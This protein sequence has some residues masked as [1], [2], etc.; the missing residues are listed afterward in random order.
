MEREALFGPALP[1]LDTERPV[2]IGD[3]SGNSDDQ[4]DAIE[5]LAGSAAAEPPE[6]RRENPVE[7]ALAEPQESALPQEESAEPYHEPAREETA[8]PAVELPPQAQAPRI[9]APPRQLPNAEARQARWRRKAP[10]AATQKEPQPRRSPFRS[11][12]Q[13]LHQAFANYRSAPQ[14]ARPQK[15][16]SGS[17]SGTEDKKLLWGER[18]QKNAAQLEIDLYIRR[19]M[20]ALK[21]R[22]AFYEET[23]S[24]S[25][26]VH[27]RVSVV[28][29]IERSGKLRHIEVRPSTGVVDVDRAIEQFCRYATIPPLPSTFPDNEL[30][31]PI[32]VRIEQAAGIHR[33]R[34]TVDTP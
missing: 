22:A 11:D 2:L 33:M 14:G 24:V 21:D 9:A 17:G 16:G 5:Q 6:N 31:L 12:G 18:A 1:P 34:F 30:V 23:V 4:N 19:L 15:N 10:E 13:T 3:P 20:R 29:V 27:T 26:S 32:Q 28:M 8:E 7:T 25:H